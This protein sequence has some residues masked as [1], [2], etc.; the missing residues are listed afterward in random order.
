[1][2]EEGLIFIADYPLIHN[3]TNV[4]DV[5]DRNPYDEREMRYSKSPIAIFA[6]VKNCYTGA[7][8]LKALAIQMDFDECKCS[9]NL[10]LLET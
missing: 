2:T 5:L 3:L 10:Y 8:Q 4:D 6:S 1:M 7:Y 9:C